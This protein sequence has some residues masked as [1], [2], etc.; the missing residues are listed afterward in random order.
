M[1][2]IWIDCKDK[3]QHAVKVQKDI[4]FHAIENFSSKVLIGLDA[5]LDYGIDILVGSREARIENLTFPL[6]CP[7][8]QRFKKVEIKPPRG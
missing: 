1:I 5:I 2:P 8:N 7:P 4:E 3:K 6:F